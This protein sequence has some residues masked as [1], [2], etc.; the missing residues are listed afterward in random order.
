M[1][2]TGQ[3]KPTTSEAARSCNTC[4]N[5]VAIIQ[6]LTAVFTHRHYTWQYFRMSSTPSWRSSSHHRTSYSKNG[7]KRHFQR[8][9]LSM[10]RRGMQTRRKRASARDLRSPNSSSTSLL[11]PPST[12]PRSLRLQVRGKISA[13]I[14]SVSICTRTSGQCC[15]LDGNFGR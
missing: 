12:Q 5:T 6:K 7:S 10:L 13:W 15:S 1:A 2:S 9:A 11:E 4:G 14:R 8:D 3:L